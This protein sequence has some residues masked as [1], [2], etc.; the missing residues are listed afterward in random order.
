VNRNGGAIALGHPLGMSG[1]RI[2]GTA[3][4][5][6]ASG[7][8]AMPSPPCASASVRASR[9]RSS[10]CDQRS[11][12]GRATTCML[13]ADRSG[14]EAQKA[15]AQD[16]LNRWWWPCLMMF[17]PPD[18]QQPATA[19]NRSAWKH[20]ARDERRAAAEVRRRDR[21]AGASYLGHDRARC[22]TSSG[23]RHDEATGSI[24]AIDW[25][26]FYAAVRGEGP[27][28]KERMKARR[29]AW[30]EGA[31]VREAADAYEAK[32]AARR[33]SAAA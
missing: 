13:H 26:E 4:W 11:T 22:R 15:M 33:T 31:W 12:S 25:D 23:T 30:D 16:A 2:T 9:S 19:R 27:V 20:Q 18:S 5:N 29:A 17:G 14:T 8:A 1:A 28:A 6:C 21:A 32:Q 7:A 10:A 24:G 3:R